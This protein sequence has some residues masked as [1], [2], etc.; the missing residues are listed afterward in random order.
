MKRI[1][2][3]GIRGGVGATTIAANLIQALKLNDERVHIIDVRP[4]NLMR[5]HFAMDLSVQ[6]GWAKRWLNGESWKNAAYMSPDSLSF[7]PYGGLT[8]DERF[9]FE[10]KLMSTSQ[11]LLDIFS[12]QPELENMWQ[13]IL[14]PTVHELNEHYGELLASADMVLCVVKP[15][16][17]NYAY[18]QQNVSFCRFVERYQPYY[19]INGYQPQSDNSVDLS[20]VLKYELDKQCLPMFLHFDT[21]VPDACSQLNLVLNYAPH[22]QIS[23][24]INE[25]SFW[26]LTHFSAKEVEGK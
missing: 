5:F 20:L 22:S 14:L 16:I 18:I 13:I 1:I 10:Q 19:L 23:Q 8:L 4:E 17:Q 6:D 2:I 25:L 24:G 7:I 3:T 12:I 11:G 26:L 21:A 9:A 15:D